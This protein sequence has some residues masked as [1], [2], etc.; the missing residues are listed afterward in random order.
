MVPELLIPP[1]IVPPVVPIDPPVV[2]PID[3]ELSGPPL[4]G[5]LEGVGL[6][7]GA[8]PGGLTAG[9]VVWFWSMVGVVG[10]VPVVLGCIG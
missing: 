7:P 2:V 3:P 4:P 6:E 8:V 10:P 9:D 1:L 5:P